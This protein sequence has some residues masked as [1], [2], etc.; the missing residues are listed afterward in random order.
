MAFTAW[1]LLKS[2]G[3]QTELMG[4]KTN[5]TIPAGAPVILPVTGGYITIATA[6]A[7]LNKIIGMTMHAS[8]AGDIVLCAPGLD[9]NVF[10]VAV[11]ATTVP[12]VGG[13]YQVATTDMTVDG[14]TVVST[15]GGVKV[16]A[17]TAGTIAA[18]TKVACIVD[19]WHYIN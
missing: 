3:D 7:D 8:V 4:F 1:K 2:M 15:A 10:E 18:P 19:G 16:L 6:G 11:K 12:V 17:V 9:S 13:K 14:A 5:S